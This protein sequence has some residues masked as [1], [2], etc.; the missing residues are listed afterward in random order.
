MGGSNFDLGLDL[1]G[2]PVLRRSAFFAAP[3][4]RRRLTRKWAA[5]P[6][7]LVIGHNPS[8]ADADVDDPTSKWW[9]RWF[10]HYGFGAYDAVNLYPFCSPSPAVCRARITAAW[11]GEWHD[12]D[13]LHANLDDVARMAKAADQVFACWGGIAAEDDWIEHVVEH[14]QGGP[15]PWPHLWCWGKTKHGAPT[16]PMARGKHRIAWDTPAVLWRE[17]IRAV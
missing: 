11:E 15:E 3:D 6:R 10:Y 2:A 16:H 12:R 8:T 17:S 9:N 1:F 14:I 4:I 5:G 7:A 13:Q